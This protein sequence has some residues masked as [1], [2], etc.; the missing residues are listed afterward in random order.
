MATPAASTGRCAAQRLA[1][2]GIAPC[3]GSVGDSHDSVVAESTIGLYKTEFIARRRPWRTADAVKLATLPYI[4][5]STTA[6]C[7]ARSAM[8]HP[9]VV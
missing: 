5:C 4:D 2:A 7:V 8:S 6:D 1:D 9:R 3:V